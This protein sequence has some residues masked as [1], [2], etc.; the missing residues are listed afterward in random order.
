MKELII[1]VGLPKTGT[2]AL[3]KSL[4]ENREAL[5]SQGVCYPEKTVAYRHQ[6]L[7]G[8][9]VSQQPSKK[10]FDDY[11]VDLPRLI[12][13]AE[14]ISN[15]FHEFT[16]ESIRLFKQTTRSFRKR[17][18][19][20]KRNLDDFMW[21]FYKQCL[22]NRPEGMIGVYGLDIDF[23]KF[24]TLPPIQ[25]FLVPEDLASKISATFDAELIL[26]EYEKITTEDIFYEITKC[27]LPTSEARSRINLSLPDFKV[28][29]VRRINASLT[30]IQRDQALSQ[31]LRGNRVSNLVELRV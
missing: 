20:V 9:F 13:S 5:F 1:H 22:L 30:G 3:Q 17:V 2:S 12:W 14:G 16:V 4:F 6:Y 8:N 31:L 29:S 11:I 28:D 23:N 18:V 15:H 27:A 21:S 19:F 10:L 7:V 24:L 25:K 26:L